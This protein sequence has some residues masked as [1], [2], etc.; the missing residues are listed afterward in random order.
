MKSFFSFTRTAAL[1]LVV[2]SLVF[3]CK[4]DDE[5]DPI[6]PQ[7]FAEEVTGSDER[8]WGEST[9]EWVG[10]A[11][12]ISEFVE[13]RDLRTVHPEWFENAASSFKLLDDTYVYV[14]NIGNFASYNSAL[15]YYTY[16]EDDIRKIAE[17]RGKEYGEALQ[18]F[19]AQKIFYRN[20]DTAFFRNVIFTYTKGLALGTTFQIS[21]N[22]AKLKKGTIIG[23]Y[24]L[25]N[26]GIDVE[27]NPGSTNIKHR[28]NDQ[29]ASIP[30]FIA[31]DK[32]ANV[33]KSSPNTGVASHVIGQSAC[34][35]L[36]I[37]FED[38]NPIYDS[39]KPSG[40]YDCNDVVFAVGDN[41]K[42]R[43]NTNLIAYNSYKIKT[44]AD[45]PL[46]GAEENCTVE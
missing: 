44:V 9:A 11:G 4:K 21:D 39:D 8:N 5:E 7:N 6:P 32:E 12:I 17:K 30:M 3:G 2:S 42:E 28:W 26:A 37:S 22:G 36:I 13:L 46:L 34:G 14:T 16:T 31:S 10:S 45:L 43:K 33:K 23:F 24:L 29:G 35:D 18:A 20:S 15:G 41:L 25:P 40:D 38:T 1:L 19:I 27:K